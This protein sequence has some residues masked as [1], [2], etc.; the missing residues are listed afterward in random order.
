MSGQLLKDKTIIIVGAGSGLGECFAKTFASQGAR[1][2]I[3]GRTAWKLERVAQEIAEAGGEARPLTADYRSREDACRVFAAAAEHFGK[4]DGL[5]TNATHPSRNLSL[6]AA[7]DDYITALVETD[8]LGL[9]WYNREALRFFLQQGS[10]CILNI[11]SNNI[12]RP[13]CDAVYCAC[14]YAAW[15]LTRQMAMRCV[16]TDV[17]CNLLNPG[18]FQS[19]GSSVSMSG[20][21]HMYDAEEKVQASGVIPVTDGSMNQILKARTNRAVPVDLSQVANAAVYLLSDYAAHVNG[22]MFTV[23]RGG[24]L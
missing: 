5:V 14:K 7:D 16:G 1:V 17:R 20:S 10:G 12:G 19:S 22:Q 24:Y 13:I 11:G 9:M 3:T 18:S 2:V 15:G 6:E 8:V 23:D 4:V 21:D